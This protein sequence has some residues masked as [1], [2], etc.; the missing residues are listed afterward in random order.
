MV[1]SKTEEYFKST[2]KYLVNN[3]AFGAGASSSLAGLK[4]LDNGWK[5][6]KSGGWKL[7]PKPIVYSHGNDFFT[8]LHSKV[9]FDVAVSGGTLG[10]FYAIGLLQK[11]YKVCIIER[12][13][14]AGRSQEWNISE[15]ELR[16]LIRLNIITEQDMEKIKS[17]KF[18]PARVGFK[19]DT[20]SEAPPNGYEL[21]VE[22]ILNLGIRP[23]ILISILKEKFIRLGGTVFEDS[24]VDRVDVYNDSAIISKTTNANCSSTFSCKLLIDSMG[25]ASPISRQTRGNVEPD[26]ICIVVGSCAQGYNASNNTYSDIIYTDSPITAITDKTN[27][28]ADPSLVES[29]QLQYFWEAFPAGS[30]K[31]DRTTYLFTYMDAKPERPSVA[32]IFDDYWRLLPRYQGVNL[33][34]LQFIRFLYGVFP[35]YRASPIQVQ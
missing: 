21:Y 11:G 16:V 12:G 18:N 27:H 25:N 20:R 4:S 6:L 23:D 1:S 2:E 19:L 7:P 13:K 5:S 10:L 24:A 17:I 32:D 33:D 3:Q 35:T 8:E 14:I 30:G 29:S 15:K 9:D 34:E 26:G 31:T 22:D 28:S